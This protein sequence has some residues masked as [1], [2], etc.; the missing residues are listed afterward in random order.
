[1]STRWATPCDGIVECIDERDEHGCESPMWLLPA[2]LL[3]AIFFLVC[4]QFCFFYKYIRKEVK[5]L[6]RNTNLKCQQSLLSI[7]CK[8]QKHTYIAMLLQGIS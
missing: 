7:S 1:M 4:S 5:E 3:V 2:I 8:H 6:A